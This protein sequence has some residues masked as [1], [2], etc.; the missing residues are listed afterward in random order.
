MMY[1]NFSAFFR[2]KS[3]YHTTDRE[4][5]EKI[6]AHKWYREGRI[7][8]I[9]EE[10]EDVIHD[11]NEENSVLQEK[12]VKQRYSILGKRMCTYIPPASSN[13]EE[14]ESR[15]TEQTGE[16]EEVIQ[17]DRDIQEDIENVTSFLEA[18]D[19]FEVRFKV[20]RSQ[21]GNKET[22]SSLCK[23]HGIQFPNYPLD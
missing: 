14:K 5:A 11:E 8:E 21:C 17:E 3:T 12:E 10:D 22:L 19:F 13:Q 9:I 18:K 23:E 15:N 20:P 7:T 2:G 6:R 1:I 4:L 16:K